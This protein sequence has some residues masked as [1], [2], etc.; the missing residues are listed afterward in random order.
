MKKKILIIIGFVVLISSIKF[1]AYE[2]STLIE[3]DLSIRERLE[4]WH[5]MNVKNY[6]DP[7]GVGDLNDN[8]LFQRIIAG[9]NY[10][11]NNKIIISVHLQ[12]S[13]AFGWSLRNSKYPD[14]FKI[15]E[16][17]TEVPYYIKNPNEEFFEIYDLFFEYRGLLNDCLN[18]KVGRQKITFGDKRIFGPG[19]WGNTGNW[20]W[21]AI[22]FLYSNNN[23]Y[24]SVFIGGTKIH[25]PKKVSI[26]FTNTEFWGGGIYGHYYFPHMINIEPFYA[27]KTAGSADYIN[28]FKFNRHWTGVRFFHPDYHSFVYD[29]TIVKEFGLD[30]TKHIDAYAYVARIGYQFKSLFSKPKLSVR[31]SNASGGTIDNKIITFDPI[32]GSSDSYYGRMNLVKWSNI[33]DNE[34]LLE[35]FPTNKLSVEISYHRF[36]ILSPENVT[37]LKTIRLMNGERYL[38]DELNILIR[39]NKF[40]HFEFIAAFGYF[41]PGKI[42]PINNLQTK[43]ASWIAL[44]VLYFMQDGTNE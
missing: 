39:F 31:R 34:I 12:D 23:Y 40:K 33:S 11:P 42:L 21:D 4:L 38:G 14:L 18:I 16:P 8:I 30:N 6:G 26:P 2:G 15:K 5:G 22:N 3:F 36:Y 28:T 41:H 13:R 7:N 10:T 1:F 17:N 20:S 44:Q 19:E 25:D 9:F 29:F 27:Y 35:L 37:L 24:V 32:Y 43:N